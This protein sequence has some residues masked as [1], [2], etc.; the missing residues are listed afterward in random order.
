MVK[1]YF[2]KTEEFKKR[3][4][5]KIEGLRTEGMLEYDEKSEKR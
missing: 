3:K 5:Q 4:M 1:K 2:T